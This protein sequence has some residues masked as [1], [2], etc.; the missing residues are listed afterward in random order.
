MAVG[1]PSGFL[2]R[3][4]WLQALLLGCAVAAA[5]AGFFAVRWSDRN[6]LADAALVRLSAESY[7][8]A[9]A[10]VRA[11]AGDA[12][13]FEAVEEAQARAGEAAWHVAERSVA[14]GAAAEA[15]RHWEALATHL[16]ALRAQRERVTAAAKLARSLNERSPALHDA[17]EQ[18]AA[19]MA[20]FG[21]GPS[22]LAAA[23]RLDLLT[24]RI[25]Q[26]ASI[27]L[28]ATPAAPDS[29]TSLQ[30]DA[31]AIDDILLG[32][33]E[34]SA[35]LRL[36]PQRNPEVRRQLGAL[37][38][39]FSGH[40]GAAAMLLEY[41]EGLSAAKS[42]ATAAV[43]RADAIASA[44]DQTRSEPRQGAAI[45]RGALLTTTAAFALAALVCLAVVLRR[46]RADAHPP[47]GQPRASVQSELGARTN[48]DRPPA[49]PHSDS[50]R[51]T[52]ANL[53]HLA[54]QIQDAAD[55]VAEANGRAERAAKRRMSQ[56]AD[57]AVEWEVSYEEL[58]T[59]LA[60]ATVELER[61]VGSLMGDDWAALDE[62]SVG[63][64]QGRP[65]AEQRKA[66]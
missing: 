53:R 16:D 1:V 34:G 39:S 46:A 54:E 3:N 14:A 32:L 10:S 7:R 45:G 63:P 42:A 30:A 11:A 41:A 22:D 20:R 61:A 56:L 47:Q 57:F 2:D 23:Q 27:L 55:K 9:Y 13:A 26:H 37:R 18:L 12:S 19:L 44:V 52:V 15:E 4:T 51:L 66:S 8:T 35:A 40:R 5:L 58:A 64:D 48:N 62:D 6:A 21:A 38:E 31:D 43:S 24:Q 33:L 25:G 65:Q 59:D 60:Q 36:A 28:A 49:E 50:P 17:V 29:S